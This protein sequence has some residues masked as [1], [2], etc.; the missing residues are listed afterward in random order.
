MTLAPLVADGKVM[1]GAS[2]G[3]LGIRGF[4]AAYDPETGAELWKTL[5]G[6]GARGAGQR[7]VAEGRSME[8]RWRLGL[9]G[10]QLRSAR[11]TWPS[12]VPATADRGWA[13]SGPATTS[14]PRRPSP[15]TW[16]RGRSRG[17][18][19]TRRT[20]RG[21]GTKCRRPSWWTSSGTAA[22]SRGSIDVAR[23]GYLWFLERTDRADQVRRGQPY[24]A[25][26][27]FRGLD[28]MTGRPDVDPARKPGTGKVADFCPS[29]WGGK[30]WP[31]IAFSPRTRLIYIPANEN[32]CAAI[33]GPRVE[34]WPGGAFTGARRRHVDRCRAPTTSAKCR[35]GTSIRAQ[36]VWTHNFAKSS[37]WGP[38]LATGGGLVFTGGT[39]GS[40]VPGRSTPVRARCCGS[41]RPTP[42]S[43]ASRRRSAST[44]GST[45]P[46]SRDGASTRAGCRTA[47]TRIRRASSRRSRRAERSGCSPS[48]R[49]YSVAF[50]TH[51]ARRVRA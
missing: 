34:Y 43:S 39:N 38:M 50:F 47:S 22:R 41:S 44:A 3:E 13:T 20:S 11:P 28:P 21:T 16:R 45:S 33:E 24:V 8:D 1:V 4:V 26:N 23:N 37:N 51:R 42:A 6:A 35:R 9:G 46:C 17:I 14:I 40:Q 12:G 10:R 15:W 30:N 49:S 27:V 32:L 31:P 25:Q 2:G 5:H 29:H 7:N 48:N 18:S 36:R 19:S